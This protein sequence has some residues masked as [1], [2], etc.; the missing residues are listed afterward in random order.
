MIV[1]VK[2]IYLYL[3]GHNR[4]RI[5]SGICS[6]DRPGICKFWTDKT[7][8]EKLQRPTCIAR[9]GLAATDKNDNQ[10]TGKYC[11][12]S[13]PQFT[14]DVV[15]YLI[16]GTRESQHSI[17]FHSCRPIRVTLVNIPGIAYCASSRLA[18]I[19]VGLWVT[20]AVSLGYERHI[21]SSF[22]HRATFL[23]RREGGCIKLWIQPFSWCIVQV[24]VEWLYNGVGEVLFDFARTTSETGVCDDGV[25]VIHR[26][27]C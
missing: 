20:G 18:N 10:I 5:F 23:C 22:V 2:K 14:V 19:T 6:K 17:R 24:V 26:F 13:H 11:I 27:C 4:S 15:Q 8:G 3:R 25:G 16:Q 1:G 12:E 9:M 7:A 21:S